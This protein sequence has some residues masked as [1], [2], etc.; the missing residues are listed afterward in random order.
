MNFQAALEEEKNK[1][2]PAN[3]EARKQRAEW[4][5]NDENERKL[6]EERVR[7]YT[8]SYSSFIRSKFIC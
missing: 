4:I 2:M 7:F 6:A 5:L 1:K 3:W 8:L